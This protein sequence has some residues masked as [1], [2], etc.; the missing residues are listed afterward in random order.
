LHLQLRTRGQSDDQA[1]QHHKRISAPGGKRTLET[2]FFHAVARSDTASMKAA[3]FAVQLN[4][5]RPAIVV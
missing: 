1:K 4:P 2:E 5:E 3:L